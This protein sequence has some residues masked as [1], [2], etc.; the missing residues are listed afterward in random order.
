[1]RQWAILIGLNHY[2]LFQPLNCAQQD[3]QALHQFL[4]EEAGFPPEQCLL[5]TDT[6]PQISGRSSQP[7]RAN[8]QGWI[9][10]LTQQCFK[11]GDRLWFFFSG[12]GVCA[13][14]RDYLAPL[15]GDPF[16]VEMTCIPLS[17]ILSRLQAA[18]S[19]GLPL[20]LLDINRTQGNYSN[21]HVGTQT[22]RLATE[23]KIPAML[24]CQPGQYSREI[25]G[26]GHGLFTIGLLD[27]LRYRQAATPE[28]LMRFLGDRLPELGEH[29][30]LPNQHPSATCPPDQLHQPLLDSHFPTPWNGATNGNGTPASLPSDATVFHPLGQHRSHSPATIAIAEPAPIA[31]NPL[32]TTQQTP[33]YPPAT[34]TAPAVSGFVPPA[35]APQPATPP[36]E[37]M[38]APDAEAAVESASSRLWRSILL[39]GS[40]L[41]LALVGFVLWRNWANIQAPGSAK[42][43]ETPAI[44]PAPSVPPPLPTDGT[45]SAS[46][47]LGTPP[48]PLP[49]PGTTAAPPVTAPPSADQTLNFNPT[50][51]P[52]PLSGQAIL[53]NARTQVMSDQATPYRNAIDAA[54]QIQPSDP[55]YV[56]AQQEIAAWSQRIF[57]IAQ[58][59]SIQKQWDIAIM[60]A[61]L[62]PE[63]DRKLHPQAQALISQWCPVLPATSTDNFAL[64]KAKG[65]CAQKPI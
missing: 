51:P 7:T 20:V 29:Y 8:L 43:P 46:V 50:T 23:L 37:S 44:A 11:P 61:A 18:L 28:I 13:Q 31:S 55:Y 6:S 10:F 30:Y 47:T 9:E 39:V 40:L 59:R 53:Q 49:S 33:L 21:E 5:M 41:S 36:G 19:P 34:R 58:Q 35:P 57:E 48:T 64:Q 60:A 22:M 24:S 52:A 62:V 1:M 2:Q 45:Q 15:D 14:G 32:A 26:V 56:D 27:A 16:A 4:I 63:D 3:A 38:P 12:Y 65:I 54:K 17:D 25:S 42:R